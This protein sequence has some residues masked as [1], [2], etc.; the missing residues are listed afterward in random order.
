MAVLHRLT[1]LTLSYVVTVCYCLYFCVAVAATTAVATAANVL[2][3]QVSND[4]T[5]C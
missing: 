5:S 2:R 3:F 4:F 1:I